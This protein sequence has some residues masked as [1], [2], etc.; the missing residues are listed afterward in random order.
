MEHLHLRPLGRRLRE[1]QHAAV[2]FKHPVAGRRHCA[3]IDRDNDVRLVGDR[4][5]QGKLRLRPVGQLPVAVHRCGVGKMVVRHVRRAVVQLHAVRLGDVAGIVEGEHLHLVQPLGEHDRDAPLL[6]ADGGDA[7]PVVEANRDLPNPGRIRRRINGAT[8][9]LDAF[10]R[11]DQA[12]GRTGD[13]DVR[14]VDIRQ[15]VDLGAKADV[16]QV[17]PVETGHHDPVGL[18]L[19]ALEL[20]V[21]RANA[22]DRRVVGQLH[23]AAKGGPIIDRHRTVDVAAGDVHVHGAGLGRRPVPPERSRGRLGQRVFGLAH[24]R[25]REGVE[26]LHHTADGRQLGGVGK[27]V[28][29]RLRHDVVGDHA[30]IIL[31]VRGGHEEGYLELPGFLRQRQVVGIDVVLLLLIREV[32][33]VVE[34]QLGAVVEDA[35]HH[36]VGHR[37]AVDHTDMDFHIGV[38]QQHRSGAGLDG[39]LHVAIRQTGRARHVADRLE[40]VYTAACG[41]Q[42]LKTGQRINRL[43][44]LFTNLEDRPFRL[45][46]LHQGQDACNMRGGH[47]GALKKVIRSV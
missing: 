7:D 31:L 10:F 20:H 2:E 3:A 22:V 23:Q 17:V 19:L 27:V 43:Q 32:A 39:H 33:I 5:A 34:I 4:L 13:R 42:S 28:V 26:R 29:L 44:E 8:G 6:S 14:R 12:V 40:G 1:H 15:A 45:K 25:G 37:G 24:L 30:Q 11:G 9:Q 36:G 41:H 38:G 35:D 46:T 16:A 18:A 21:V 47:A